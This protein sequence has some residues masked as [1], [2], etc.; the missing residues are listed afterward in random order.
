MTEARLRRGTG[1]APLAVLA[2]ITA[3]WG[4]TF[5]VVKDAVA[6]M[7]VMDFLFVR[8]AVA[9]L[10]LLGVALGVGYVGQTV[11]LRF[12]SAAVSGFITGMFVVFT[13]L[14][15]GLVLRRAVG[16]AAWA[17]VG[18]ATAGLGLLS[19]RG[20]A[21]GVGELL[22][23]LCAAAFAVHIVGLGEWSPRHDAYPLAVV[24]LGTVMVLT[25]LAA[26]PGGLALPPD[27]AAWAAVGV[28]AVLATAA[29]FLG[30]TW[31]QARIPPTRAAVV[32]TLE[33]VFAGLFAVLAGERL[34]WRTLAGGGLVLAA[35]Y[36]VELGPR[37]A[38]D[39]EVARL[40]Q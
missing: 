3:V 1:L 8:F 15:A 11:G 21:V 9:T 34:G 37:R 39:A 5:T 6:R 26:A 33:P 35:M 36:L 40:E 19:L 7:P 20:L 30:Q 29:G 25:G 13:P 16:A 18:L 2:G 23:L 32:L 31:A 14:I 4:A 12:T 27:G 24:Q 22:T 38:A 17:A 28:T 10:V